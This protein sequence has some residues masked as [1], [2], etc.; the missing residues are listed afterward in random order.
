MVRRL[1]TTL[2]KVAPVCADVVGIP[3]KGCPVVQVTVGSSS[4]DFSPVIMGNALVFKES[5]D[6]DMS[7]SHLLRAD[8]TAGDDEVATV[9]VDLQRALHELGSTGQTATKWFS[10]LRREGASR[11]S[12]KI[13]IVFTVLAME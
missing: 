7:R 6:F 11:S 3:L 2:V 12:G 5:H 1:R 13:L 9:V 8:I 4:V 10:L